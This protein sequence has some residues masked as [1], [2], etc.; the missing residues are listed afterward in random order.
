MANQLLLDI[1]PLLKSRDFRLLFAGQLV[2]MFGSQLTMVAIP[3]QVYALTR[4]SL[5]VGAVSLAQLVPLIVGALVGGSIGDTFERR[6]ILLVSLSALSLT[7]AALAFNAS[8]AHPSVLAVYLISAAGAALGGVVSTAC[9]AAVPSLV[10]DGQLVAAYAAM[11]VVDQVAMVAG[12]ALSG[13]LIGTVRVP[14]VYGI[15]AVTFV[16]MGLA[17]VRMGATSRPMGVE[18]PKRASVI[19]GLRYLRGRP[20]MQGAYLIDLNATVFGVPRALFPALAATVFHG[21]PST[22][23]LLYAA[24]GAGALLGAFTTGWLARI[25]RQAWAVIVAVGV[26]GTAIAIFGLVHALWAALALLAIAGWADVIS[27]VLRTTILQTAVSEAFRARV[28]SVQIAVVEGGPRL[29][30]LE[31]GGVGTAVSTEFAVVSGGLACI[32]GAVLLAGVL[33]AF[34]RYH[35]PNQAEA[36]PATSPASGCPPQ[37]GDAGPGP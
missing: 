34:R 19:E 23:G 26:W 2:S 27:A 16:V 1:D 6:H 13:L 7:S 14:W 32:A 3:Y 37:S 12:P 15:D 9:Q 8:F 18:R 17:M 11:Q 24:P 25:R 28:S 29:G 36:L 22:L 21:G 30:D 4:S 35:R 20:V 10:E 33:P 31:A 5:Q